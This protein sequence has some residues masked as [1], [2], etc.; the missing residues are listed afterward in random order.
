MEGIKGYRVQV[1]GKL[2][3][4]PRLAV[5]LPGVYDHTTVL[6]IVRTCLSLYKKKNQ[7]GE[8]FGELLTRADLQVLT[9]AFASKD[10]NP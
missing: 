10:L 5:E 2:G 3:R 1:G 6:E 9:A 8:R 4:H 7:M